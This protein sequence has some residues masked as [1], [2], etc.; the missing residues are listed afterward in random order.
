MEPEESGIDRVSTLFR[1]LASPLRVA[2]VL[3]LADG[4]RCV[5]ELVDLLEVPQP[6]VSQHLRVLRESDL[7]VRVRRGREAAYRLSDDHVSHIVRDALAHVREPAEESAPDD[8][9]APHPA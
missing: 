2:L 3:E 6:L 1:S 5:H 7:V 9:E 8:D 4:E